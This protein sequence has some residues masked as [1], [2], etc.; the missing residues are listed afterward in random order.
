MRHVYIALR[1]FEATDEPKTETRDN[2]RRARNRFEMEAQAVTPAS[3][4][5]LTVT[6]SPAMAPAKSDQV[7]RS[8]VQ[9]QLTV[10]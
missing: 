8:Q 4:P 3:V 9:V 1:P 7:R 2:L 6:S 10:F 5:V